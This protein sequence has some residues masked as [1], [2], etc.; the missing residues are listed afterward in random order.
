MDRPHF[1][2]SLPVGC[3]QAS[4]LPGS[5][6]P[7]QPWANAEVREYTF[8]SADDD[9]AALVPAEHDPTVAKEGTREPTSSE[10]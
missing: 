9:D 6:V 2:L 7:L 1:P 10:Q 5:F 3:R 4:S 8:A